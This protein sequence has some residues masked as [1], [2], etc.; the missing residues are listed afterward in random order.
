MATAHEVETIVR[1]L[2][3]RLAELDP[4]IRGRAALHR[5]VSCRVVDLGVV[6]SGRVCEDGLCDLTDGP[7][8]RAQVRLA[9]SS[10]D[11][12]AL[13]VGRLAVRT[14]WASGRLRVQAGP[15]DLL[16]LRALL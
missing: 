5:T 1:G 12:L 14:A 9:V 7:S 8:R 16:T 4:E 10:D 6:W 13:S 3:V 15:L 2:A 11:L